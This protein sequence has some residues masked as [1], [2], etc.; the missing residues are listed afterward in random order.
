MKKITAQDG[1]TADIQ[2]IRLRLAAYENLHE[3]LEFEQQALAKQLTEMR[4]AGKEKTA[5][6]RDLMTKK[7][8]NAYVLGLF[9]ARGL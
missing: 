1:T 3:S 2:A 6:Y 4:A 9:A 8:Q 7:M 5:T